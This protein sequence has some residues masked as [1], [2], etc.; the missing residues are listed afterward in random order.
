MTKFAEYF[1]TVS[2]GKITALNYA[3]PPH[4]LLEN[5]I[6][7]THEEYKLLDAIRA[8]LGRLSQLV[9]S[10]TYKLGELEDDT[11]IQS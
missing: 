11:S 6:S 7:L 10:I 9:A 4:E 1:A 3:H 5:Q 8:D 2:D